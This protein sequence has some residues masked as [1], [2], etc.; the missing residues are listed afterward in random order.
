MPS[1]ANPDQVVG[2]ETPSSVGVDVLKSYA[3]PDFILLVE[4]GEEVA[5]VRVTRRQA[6][7]LIKLMGD[8]LWEST[9]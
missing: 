4:R 6:D 2:H 1:P 9:P 3:T 7:A 8:V 5:L